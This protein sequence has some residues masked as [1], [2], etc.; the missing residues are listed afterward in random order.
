MFLALGQLLPI[1]VALALSSVTIMATIAILL[2]PNRERA[3]VPFL[4]GSVVGL[5]LV[6]GLFVLFARAIPMP[7]TRRPQPGLAV[8]LILIGIAVIVFAV[9]RLRR[10]V[11]APTGKTPKWLRTVGSLGA[12]SSFGLALSLNLRPKALLLGTATGLILRG[13]GLPVSGTLIVVAIY[14]TV[15]LSTIAVP[16]IMTLA[17]PTKM[18]KRLHSGREWVATHSRPV[19]IVIMI[20]IGVVI[21]G[22]GISRL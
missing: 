21:I 14:V 2:S 20:V 12:L 9:I 13:N 5:V 22:S 17:S 4:L 6:T 15:S 7:P 11:K 19:T 10:A 3:A 16:I 18:E 8:A 1:A